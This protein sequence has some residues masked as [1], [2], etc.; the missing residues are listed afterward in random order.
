MTTW[1]AV[2]GLTF[3]T[4]AWAQ[5]GGLPNLA[6]LGGQM[7]AAA[8]VCG[9]H[10]ADELQKMKAAQKAQSLQQGVSAEAFDAG[11]QKGLD[12]GLAKFKPLSAAQKSQTCA[13]LKAL[14]Q[15]KLPQR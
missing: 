13:Q 4:A 14:S 9:H 7:H 10:S 8:Q 5:S 15:V 12:D 2:A 3:T 1:A 6:E 11:F